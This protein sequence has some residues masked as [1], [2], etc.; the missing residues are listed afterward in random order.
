MP[1]PVQVH[2]DSIQSPVKDL[3]KSHG[4]SL[5]S[6]FK[7]VEDYAS[8]I[9]APPQHRIPVDPRSVSG[10]SVSSK[11]SVYQEF[12]DCDIEV[13][14]ELG[15]GERQ[16]MYLSG[17]RNLVPELK[18]TPLDQAQS[19]KHFSLLHVA[20]KRDKMPFLGPTTT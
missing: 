8:D 1:T 11:V 2:P 6:I 15:R 17:L 16:K 13:E 20:D 5:D 4:Y 14:E 12:E 9:R 19:L 3:L 7:E 10:N 18:H